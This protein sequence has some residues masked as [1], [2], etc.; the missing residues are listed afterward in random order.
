LLTSEYALLLDAIVPLECPRA[1]YRGWDESRWGRTLRIADWHR[2]SPVL[3]SYVESHPSPPAAVR[4][5]FE[6]AYLANAARS[7]FIASATRKVIEALLAADVPAMLL[8]GA[9]LVETVYPDPAQREMLDLDVLVPAGRLSAANE[10]L[11]PMGY[12]AVSPG[13]SPEQTSVQ[14]EVTE[15]HDPALIGEDH[16]LAVELHHHV[17]IAGEG[18]RFDIDDFWQRARTS[19]NGG[20]LLPSPE[21][22]LLHVCLH[23]TRNRLGGSYRHRH[24]GGA[25]G[26][27]CDIARVVE[28]EPLD[29]NALVSAARSYR[30]GARVFLALFAAREL[31]VSVPDAPMT[32][33]Q[34]RGFD[35]R[36]G[37]RLVA[38]RVM[39][40]G[41]HL[42]V[43]TLRWMFAPSREVLSR[44]WNADSTATLSLARAYLRRV[45]ANAPLARSAL[46]RPWL[47]VQDWR[48]NDQIRMLEAA[49]E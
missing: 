37:R 2:L 17:T 35:P 18:I 4:S 47:F 45:R 5:A 11:A 15:H 31:G 46:R 9:A 39:R 42:P 16:L 29:W 30:L 24:T 22:L 21:D 28:H 32:E 48:L 26:Q 43:R 19:A 41:D 27:V 12:R 34:P 23:F 25:L 1:D 36:V 13:P 49:H 3:F 33:L 20:H 14:L 7:L 44:G 8:K 40:G 6:R 38:L 10:A